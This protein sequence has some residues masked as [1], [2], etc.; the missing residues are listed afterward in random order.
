M[1][2]QFSVMDEFRYLKS[3]YF[4]KLNYSQSRSAVVKPDT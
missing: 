2:M 3:D 4:V 1:T